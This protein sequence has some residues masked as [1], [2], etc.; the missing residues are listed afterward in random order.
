K[1]TKTTTNISGTTIN[2]RRPTIGSIRRSALISVSSPAPH[3]AAS[4]GDADTPEFA[5]ADGSGLVTH[6]VVPADGADHVERQ[7]RHG[8]LLQDHACHLG[9]SLAPLLLVLDGVGLVQ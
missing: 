1:L 9:E 6:H 4:L 2:S 8:T 7:R 3:T 5:G